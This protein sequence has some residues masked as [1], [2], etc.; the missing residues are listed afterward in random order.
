MLSTT[1]GH[2]SSVRDR[3]S[4]VAVHHFAYNKQTRV[5]LM[6]FAGI[7]GIAIE[8]PPAANTGSLDCVQLNLPIS[9]SAIEGTHNRVFRAMLC[10]AVIAYDIFAHL[11]IVKHQLHVVTDSIYPSFD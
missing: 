7:S 10:C 9:E 2:I 3:V 1:V 11:F 4:N 5:D 8:L 6:S